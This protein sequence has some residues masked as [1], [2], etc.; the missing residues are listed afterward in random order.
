MLTEKDADK[1]KGLIKAE[2]DPLRQDIHHLDKGFKNVNKKLNKLDKKLDLVV[3]LFEDDHIK[4]RKRVDRIEDHL[5][6]GQN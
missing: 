6:L 5:G 2:T 4:L 1:I 3:N